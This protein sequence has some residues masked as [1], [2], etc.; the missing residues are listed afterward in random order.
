MKN[1]KTL[2]ILVVLLLLLVAGY[3]SLHFYS[4]NEAD[5]NENADILEAVTGSPT[6]TATNEATDFTGVIPTENVEALAGTGSNSVNEIPV[7]SVDPANITGFGFVNAKGEKMNFSK[8]DGVWVYDVDETVA[9]DQESMESIALEFAQ[10]TTVDFIMDANPAD[11]GFD[12][13]PIAEFYV[14]TINEKYDITYSMRN[15]ITGE[16]YYIL[17]NDK[18]LIYYTADSIY[19]LIDTVD[20]E[21][22]KAV[23]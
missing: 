2:I 8:K 15:N 13:A 17:D 22:V 18:S 6:V 23:Q 5:K 19:G 16:Y 1:A 10:L 3:L 9:I 11:F 12:K 14:K 21:T 4:K 7:F 20:L